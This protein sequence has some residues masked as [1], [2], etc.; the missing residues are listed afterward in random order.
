MD[1]PFSIL[2]AYQLNQEKVTE[3]PQNGYRIDEILAKSRAW[4][5]ID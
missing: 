5:I 4:G 1:A 2:L 3:Y